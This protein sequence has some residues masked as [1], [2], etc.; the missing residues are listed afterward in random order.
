[1]GTPMVITNR[2]QIAHLLGGRVAEVVPFDADAFAA[3]MQRL[4]TDKERYDCYRANC[5][6]MISDTFSIKAVVD[7]L[8]AVYERVIADRENG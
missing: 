1:M 8:E 5:Q 2:C 4:L 3:A 7:R 6:E